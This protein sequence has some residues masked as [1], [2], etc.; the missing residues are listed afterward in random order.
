MD[1]SYLS[2]PIIPL[3]ID[4]DYKFE[5][6]R[7]VDLLLAERSVHKRSPLVS[8]LLAIRS[9]GP[10]FKIRGIDEKT[11][12]ENCVVCKFSFRIRDLWTLTMK[13]IEESSLESRFESFKNII[14]NAFKSSKL[15]CIPDWEV[16]DLYDA[17]SPRHTVAQLSIDD[18]KGVKV[19]P[20]SWQREFGEPDVKRKALILERGFRK[21]SRETD[22]YLETY[23]ED[24]LVRDRTDRYVELGIDFEDLSGYR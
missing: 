14:R 6:S 16:L 15:V 20:P 11:G 1:F 10:D 22:L 9:I 5:V 23:Y 12:A 8:Y 17:R 2:A 21:A 4:S 7:G 19:V 18:D 24:V 3:H 13:Y